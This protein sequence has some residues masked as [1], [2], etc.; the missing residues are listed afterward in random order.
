MNRM[1]LN[2]FSN[3]TAQSVQPAGYVVA[4]KTGT[5]ETDNE[6]G[7]AD[8]WV[9]GYTADLVVASCQGYD[10]TDEDHYLKNYTTAAIGQ[11]VK[12]EIETV[13]QYTAQTQLSVDDSELEVIIRD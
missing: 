8:R 6:V 4:G 3:G 2:V 12:Q 11:V 10:H 9:V 5:T 7:I 1:L 13:L